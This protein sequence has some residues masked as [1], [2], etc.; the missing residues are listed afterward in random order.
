MALLQSCGDIFKAKP[1]V[2]QQHNNVIDQVGGL[3]DDFLLA[4]GGGRQC[5]FHAFFADLLRDAPGAGCS[6]PGCVAFVAAVG[7]A[8]SDDRLQCGDKFNVGLV[9]CRASSSN[10][11][12]VLYQVVFQVGD[13]YFSTVE[14]ARRQGAIDTGL[15]EDVQEVLPGPGAA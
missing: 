12:L 3:V 4:A 9:H 6:E 7:Q 14:D 1:G 8:C 2:G 15:L 5:E 13:W 10:V 11:D